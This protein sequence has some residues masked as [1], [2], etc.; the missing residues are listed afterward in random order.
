MEKIKSYKDLIV[1]Q[2]SHTN[3]LE[4]I[5]LVEGFKWCRSLDVIGKQLIRSITSV[6]ANIAEGYGSFQGKEYLTFLVFAL[7]SAWESDNWLTLLKD[8]T[9]LKERFDNTQLKLIQSRNMEVIRML[10]AIIKKLRK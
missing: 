10:S 9:K 3:S 5:E 2:K 7:R 8:S 6:G 1:W 4:I